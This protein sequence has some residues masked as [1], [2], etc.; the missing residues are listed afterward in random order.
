MRKSHK[1]STLIECTVSLI[2]IGMAI[3]ILLTSYLTATNI[4]NHSNSTKD[5]GNQAYQNIEFDNLD[6]TVLDMPSASFNLGTNSFIVPCELQTAITE[7]A[8][9]KK[10]VVKTSTIL[11]QTGI[12]ETYV[13]GTTVKTNSSF[14]DWEEEK[15]NKHIKY[16]KGNTFYYRGNCYILRENINIPSL[17]NYITDDYAFSLI[18]LNLVRFTGVNHN[19]GTGELIKHGDTLLKNGIYYINISLSRYYDDSE[20][21]N[22]NTGWLEVLE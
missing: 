7:K 16:K 2:I 3:V 10:I 6:I 18:R 14:P 5:N 11:R 9:L 21:L 19:Q 12:D 4:V 22:K 8:V 20:I 15:Q 17:N 1:G 13:P